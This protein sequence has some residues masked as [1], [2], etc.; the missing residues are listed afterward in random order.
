MAL[1]SSYLWCL[2]MVVSVFLAKAEEDEESAS[3]AELP[4]FTTKL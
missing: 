3:V 1:Q 2:A 4:S